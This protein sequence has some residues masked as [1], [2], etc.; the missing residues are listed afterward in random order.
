MGH[1]SLSNGTIEWTSVDSSS[2]S[3][4]VFLALNF[5]IS[6]TSAETYLRLAILGIPFC[7]KKKIT[8]LIK[9]NFSI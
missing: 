4:N 8:I 3:D 7:L 5:K 1:F 9:H 6:K 2:R